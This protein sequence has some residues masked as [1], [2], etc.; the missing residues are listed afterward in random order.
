MKSPQSIYANCPSATRCPGC[1]DNHRHDI[2]PPEHFRTAHTFTG[3]NVEAA[4]KQRLRQPGR[5]RNPTGEQQYGQ[6]MDSGGTSA[7]QGIR[8]YPEASQSG[9]GS[10]WAVLDTRRASLGRPW[11]LA[12]ALCRL[13]WTTWVG[14]GC[15]WVLLEYS[16]A[17]L[18]RSEHFFGHSW[19]VLG[20]SWSTLE[21]FGDIL[22]ASW[23][24]RVTLGAALGGPWGPLESFL[25]LSVSLLERSRG[26]L[27][28]SW[29]MAGPG[30]MPGRS[31]GP[32][33]WIFIGFTKI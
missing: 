6:Q 11:A 23:G 9:L 14:L 32:P 18:G 24:P 27:G 7:K 21:S 30:R 10:F 19:A 12:N 29:G 4:E 20:R 5:K 13:L 26:T 8:E 15:S 2:G 33:E 22:D 16:W 28:A 1:D 31:Q 17:V 25:G 3:S